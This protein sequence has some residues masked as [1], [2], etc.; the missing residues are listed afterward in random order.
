MTVTKQLENLFK[1]MLAEEQAAIARNDNAMQESFGNMSL[2]VLS[3]SK[4][5]QKIKKDVGEIIWSDTGL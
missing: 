4:Q 2:V 5:V 1:V 3:I